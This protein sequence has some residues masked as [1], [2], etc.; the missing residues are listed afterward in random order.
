MFEARLGPPTWHFYYPI[1]RYKYGMGST[2]G[3]EEGGVVVVED[4]HYLSTNCDVLTFWK[5]RLVL[6]A[7]KW[8]MFF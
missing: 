3:E 5:I 6:V 7:G 8:F 1:K 4:K 2:W